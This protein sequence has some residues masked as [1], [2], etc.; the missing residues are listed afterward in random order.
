MALS[1]FL[2]P[3]LVDAL[4]RRRKLPPVGHREKFPAALLFSDISGFTALSERLH[5]RGR[6]GAEEVANVVN[7]VFRP[8]LRTLEQWGG[9]VCNFGG[10]SVFVLFLGRGSVG[11]ANGAAREI[12]RRIESGPRID[13][14]VGPTAIAIKQVIHFGRVTGLH[15]G[16]GDRRRYLVVGPPVMA[17][18][19][20]EESAVTSTVT[21]SAAA[22]RRLREESTVRRRSVRRRSKP[23]TGVLRGYVLPHVRRASRDF[24]GEFRKVAIVFLE[25]HGWAE[26]SLR[27]FD[28]GL[29]DVLLKYGGTRISPDISPYGSKWLCCFGAPTTHEDDPERA[30]RALLELQGR[31]EGVRF[32]AGMHVGTV[33][34]IWVGNSSRRSL[35]LIG[36][37]V[38]TAAR[39]LGVSDWGEILVTEAG[40]KRLRGITTASRGHFR[41]KG[42][43]KPLLLHRIEGLESTSDAIHVSAPWWEGSES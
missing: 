19:R 6:E 2:P 12:L 38:N 13:T 7:R 16:E 5:K 35:E 21:L 15:L 37:V 10:D 41:V 36:D 14:S 20:L 40:R 34:N 17:L 4:A 31:I 9:S 29:R 43:S 18:A 39:T 1:A 11:R 25:T 3:H 23:A 22:R 33:A 24:R 27:R 28:H 32:R 42:K 26:R 8:V 30:A